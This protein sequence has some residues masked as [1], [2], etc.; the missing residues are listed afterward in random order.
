M[1]C[2]DGRYPTMASRSAGPRIG[3]QS[4]GRTHHAACA[5]PGGNARLGITPKEKSNPTR[6]RRCSKEGE[7]EEGGDGGGN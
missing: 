7:E 4:Q 3:P 5:A 2:V 6:C 1:E